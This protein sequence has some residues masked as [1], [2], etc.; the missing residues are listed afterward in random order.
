VAFSSTVQLVTLLGPILVIL[1][2][3]GIDPAVS[4]AI[5]F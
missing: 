2:F 3:A 1:V 4:V 5:V